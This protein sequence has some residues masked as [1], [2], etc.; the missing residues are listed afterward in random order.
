MAA[1]LTGI[2]KLH[3]AVLVEPEL[4]TLRHIVHLGRY[5]GVGQADLVLKLLIHVEQRCPLREALCHVNVLAA[6]L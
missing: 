6:D 3:V 4:Q 2:E 5:H 1:S